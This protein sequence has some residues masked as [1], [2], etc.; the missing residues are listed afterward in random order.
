MF[1]PLKIL[2]SSY[3]SLTA[4]NPQRSCWSWLMWKKEPFI[5]FSLI[6]SISHSYGMLKEMLANRLTYNF[7]LMNL[8]NMSRQWHTVIHCLILKWIP[9]LSSWKARLMDCFELWR[10]SCFILLHFIY[11]TDNICVFIFTCFS[12]KGDWTMFAI[13]CDLWHVSLEIKTF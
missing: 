11:N 3:L 9:T 7:N 6:L 10:T 4:S 1:L 13:N 8:I 12:N 2:V 5:I